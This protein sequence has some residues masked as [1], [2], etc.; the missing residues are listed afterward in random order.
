M[1][2]FRNR[3]ASG[4]FVWGPDRAL[5]LALDWCDFADGSAIRRGTRFF[6]NSCLVGAFVFSCSKLSSQGRLTFTTS[7]RE[8]RTCSFSTGEASVHLWHVRH[9]ARRYPPLI[10]L[11]VQGGL[12]RDP[13][14]VLTI[15]IPLSLAC[16]TIY[17]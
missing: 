4:G 13:I 15:A 5:V 12:T 7:L 8:P 1:G 6:F 10:S 3:G 14:Q 16:F 9:W 2:L 11:L 17:K